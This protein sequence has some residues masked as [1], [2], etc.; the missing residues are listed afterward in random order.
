MGDIWQSITNF[1][2]LP[3]AVQHT[4]PLYHR[5]REHT[6]TIEN[7]QSSVLAAFEVLLEEVET[8]LDFVN[9]I[10]ARAFEARDYKKARDALARTETLTQ[11][12]DKVAVLRKEWRELAA[13]TAHEDD[14]DIQA[15]RR[16][17]GRLS[18]GQRTPESAYVVPILQ[19]LNKMGGS[20]KV[21]DVLDEVGKIMKPVLKDVDYEQ[22]A[23]RSTNLR[24]RNTPQWARNSM[25]QEGLLKSD[26]PRGVW[27]ISDQGY[28]LLKK[29]ADISGRLP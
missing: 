13:A 3:P 27:E 26:S 12:R 14:E 22:L 1:L 25:V 23:S 6:A 2:C 18:R 15:E 24:W 8:E 10:G 9:G 17:L 11:F 29:Q 4:P 19:A 20:G 16:N 21:A 28:A 7:E 5:F